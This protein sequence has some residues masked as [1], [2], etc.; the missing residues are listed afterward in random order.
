MCDR[1]ARS[2]P[3]EPA[4]DA[5]PIRFDTEGNC[6]F[7]RRLIVELVNSETKAAA[8]DQPMYLDVGKWT[9]SAR[10]QSLVCSKERDTADRREGS[11]LGGHMEDRRPTGPI[12]GR[13]KQVDEPRSDSVSNDLIGGR[14]STGRIRRHPSEREHRPNRGSDH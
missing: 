5:A 12:C 10:C 6:L 9:P 7:D 11:R 4:S 1:T 8:V 14:R 13:P 2:R 3:I